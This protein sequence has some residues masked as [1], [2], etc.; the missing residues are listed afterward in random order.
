VFQ[1]PVE[2]DPVMGAWAD[3]KEHGVGEDIVDDVGALERIRDKLHSIELVRF[4]C[5]LLGKLQGKRKFVLHLAGGGD[6][7]EVRVLAG[8]QQ[9]ARGNASAHHFL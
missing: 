2:A 5:V 4:T 6:V 8:E 1:R 9:A 3:F 7:S